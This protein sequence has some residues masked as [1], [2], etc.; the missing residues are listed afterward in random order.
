MSYRPEVFPN[1][2]LVVL[3]VWAVMSGGLLYLGVGEG[4]LGY[5]RALGYS[6]VSGSDLGT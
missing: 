5:G 2:Q 6:G 3:G 4:V 1:G